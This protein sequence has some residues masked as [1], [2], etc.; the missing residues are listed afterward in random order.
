[1]AVTTS[2]RVDNRDFNG[3]GEVEGESDSGDVEGDGWPRELLSGCDDG[4]G[5]EREEEEDESGG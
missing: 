2:G 3:V 4:G 5:G 1:M